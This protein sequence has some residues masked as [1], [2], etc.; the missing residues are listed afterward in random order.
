LAPAAISASADQRRIGRPASVRH[1]LAGPA[2]ARVPDPAA[3]RMAA[4]S[5]TACVDDERAKV[6]LYGAAQY[7]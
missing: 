1:C 4:N 7:A 3:T 2:P 5:M 6:Q